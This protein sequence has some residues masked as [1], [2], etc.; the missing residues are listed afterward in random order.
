MPILPII[1]NRKIFFMKQN[2]SF[3]TFCKK[4]QS[5]TVVFYVKHIYWAGRLAQSL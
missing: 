2:F 3:E 1:L 5:F 4:T